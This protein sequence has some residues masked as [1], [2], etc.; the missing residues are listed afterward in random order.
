[1]VLM[2]IR[3][4]YYFIILLFYYFIIL[5]FYYFKMLLRALVDSFFQLGSHG[6]PPLSNAL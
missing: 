4:F 5:L 1:M 2:T 3:L 6:F